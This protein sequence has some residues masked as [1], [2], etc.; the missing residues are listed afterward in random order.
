MSI[1]R[2]ENPADVAARGSRLPEVMLGVAIGVAV[3]A[4]LGAWWWPR[5]FRAQFG[6]VELPEGCSAS[7]SGPLLV[8]PTAS[9]EGATRGGQRSYP[10][11]T[12][13]RALEL[14]ST[15][16]GEL[17]FYV[18]LPD[19]QKGYASLADSEFGPGCQR[20]IQAARAQAHRLQYRS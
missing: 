7:P 14:T 1:T 10:T 16:D 15:S 4:A 6:S 8:R 18:E 2:T 5:R 13:V 19:G 20:A 3:A 17:V 12:Q 9:A 11:G